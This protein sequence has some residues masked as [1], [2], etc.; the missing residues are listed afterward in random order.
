MAEPQ[1]RN[2]SSPFGSGNME[3]RPLQILKRQS[4][5]SGPVRRGS[6]W[7]LLPSASYAERDCRALNAI[8]ED[9]LSFVIL[10]AQVHLGRLCGVPRGG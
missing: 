5:D 3:C 10:A 2:T 9:D 1:L 6:P 8:E 4:D 7:L